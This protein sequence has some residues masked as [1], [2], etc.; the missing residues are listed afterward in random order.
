MARW[1]EF[2]GEAPELA[3]AVR[4]L[5]DAHRHKTIATLRRDGG[6]RISGIETE[7]RD[8]DLW[9]G[10]MWMARKAVDLL[11]DPRFALHSGSEDP[12]EGDPSTWSGDAKLS[13]RAVE[14]GH[15]PAGGDERSHLFRADI[16]EVVWTRVGTPADHLLIDLWRAGEGLRR[17]KR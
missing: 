17:F 15:P 11:R 16:D 7:F 3:A 5:L 4:R 10:S 9:F 13:G 8:G 6:P 12:P 14:S 2:E 1:E